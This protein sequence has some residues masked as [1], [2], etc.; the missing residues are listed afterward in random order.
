M[1]R[2]RTETAGGSEQAVGQ[3]TDDLAALVRAEVEQVRSFVREELEAI[4]DEVAERG[5]HAAR[6]GAYL[7][8][9][10]ILGAGA[11]VALLALPA[12]ALRR[13]VPAPVAALLLAAGY[14]TGAAALARR[15]VEAVQE[16][17]PDTVDERI[18]DA[19]QSAADTLKEA[20]ART[21]R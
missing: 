17:A 9:A 13:V 1:P 16:A 19:K 4:R 3:L 18:E 8:G 7:T 2:S 20:A 6:G 5:K 21:T 15:G 12:L 10:A 11:G 14:G